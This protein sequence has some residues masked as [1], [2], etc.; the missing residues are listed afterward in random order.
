VVDITGIIALIPMDF[1]CDV[2]FISIQELNSCM[3]NCATSIS[4]EEASN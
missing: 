4:I 1:F 2:A 3:E